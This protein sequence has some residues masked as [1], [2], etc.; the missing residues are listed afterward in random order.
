MADDQSNL[1]VVGGTP[2]P[3]AITTE[4]TVLNQQV[5]KVVI[6]TNAVVA[7]IVAKGTS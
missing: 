7:A 4:R 2:P 5:G 3:V 6:S 1:A